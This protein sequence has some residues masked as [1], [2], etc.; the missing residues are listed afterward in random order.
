MSS[1]T[2]FVRQPWRTFRFVIVCLIEFACAS[3]IL[4]G[5][6]DLGL[7][8]SPRTPYFSKRF[9]QKS[10]LPCVQPNSSAASRKGFSQEVFTMSKRSRIRGFLVVFRLRF[11]LV[12]VF[13]KY[14]RNNYEELEYKSCLKTYVSYYNSTTLL[15]VSILPT[16][17]SISCW[18]PLESR[19]SI[20]VSYPHP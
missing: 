11:T 15:M 10:I 12:T 2:C 16:S 7:V 19:L 13:K 9:F 4:G 5:L 17:S 6:P 1:R 14:H 8:V 20:P 18:P 3:V